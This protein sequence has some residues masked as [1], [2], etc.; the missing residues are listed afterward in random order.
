MENVSD[1]DVPMKTNL[2]KPQRTFFGLSQN[3]FVLG[4]CRC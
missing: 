4:S 2:K 1:V 3:V